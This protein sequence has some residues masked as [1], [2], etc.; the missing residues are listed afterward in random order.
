MVRQA[1]QA[2]L[3]VHTEA[4]SR[5]RKEAAARARKQLADAE[6]FFGVKEGFRPVTYGE[7]GTAA[8]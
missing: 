4:D 5:Q 1:A 6:Q 3:A 8:S 7:T 2:E